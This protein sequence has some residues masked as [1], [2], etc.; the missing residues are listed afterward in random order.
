MRGRSVLAGILLVA[1]I[2]ACTQPVPGGG[3]ESEAPSVAPASVDQPEAS[4]APYV[5][6]GD[7]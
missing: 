7:Y 5:A 3:V 2:T 6:P 1:A 4:A